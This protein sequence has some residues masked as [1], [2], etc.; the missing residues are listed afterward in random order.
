MDKMNIESLVFRYL[1]GD[2]SDGERDI[3]CN[4]LND[5]AKNEKTFAVLKKIFVELEY[6][7]D[8]SIDSDAA[9]RKFQSLTVDKANEKPSGKPLRWVMVW[10]YAAAVLFI[11]VTALTAYFIGRRSPVE[12]EMAAFEVSVP[13][14]GKSSVMLPDGSSVWLNAGSHLTYS[15][16]AGS[17]SRNAHLEGEGLFTIEKNKYPFIV[18]TSHLEIHVTG[19]RFNVK[20]YP[21]D[22]KIETTLLEGEIRI[23]ANADSAPIY[24]RPNQKLSYQKNLGKARVVSVETDQPVRKEEARTLRHDAIEVYSNV[25]VEEAVSWQSGIMHIEGE[26]LES[27]AKKLGRKY[28][29]SF[30]FEDEELKTYSYSGTILDFPL[31]QVLEALKLTSPVDYQIREKTVRLYLNKDFKK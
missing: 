26:S 28:D 27:L 21:D 6:R 5:S 23:E 22:E 29:V 8:D 14:G 11:M 19:T 10:K 15:L 12:V 16:D 1:S 13:L 2:A 25:D 9:F 18:H 30:L 24:I 3:V 17:G 20:S 4:W 31:G 7:Y